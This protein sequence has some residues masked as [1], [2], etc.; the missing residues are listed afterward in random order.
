MDRIAYMLYELYIYTLHWN[1]I[2]IAMEYS[3][4]FQAQGIIVERNLIN[5]NHNYHEPGIYNTP[6]IYN[7]PWNTIHIPS[8]IILVEKSAGIIIVQC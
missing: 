3:D 4:T 7:I 8:I 5:S 2:Y 1:Y 6:G